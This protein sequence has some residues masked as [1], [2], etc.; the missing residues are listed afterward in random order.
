MEPK[1]LIKI[2]AELNLQIKQVTD[3][4][5]LL[6]EGSTV[7]FISRYRKEVTGGLDEVAIAAI[8]DRLLQLVQLDE[9]KAAVLESIEL[10]TYK[11][12]SETLLNPKSDKLDPFRFAMPKS[13]V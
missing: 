11:N 2:A 12:A 1:H 13:K 6:S 5:K 8:R 7:P 9:R 10:E 4:A 3:T